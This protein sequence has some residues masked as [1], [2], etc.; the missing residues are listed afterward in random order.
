MSTQINVT[1]G[2]QRLLQNVQTRS[3]ANRQAL[4]D[5]QQNTKTIAEVTSALEQTE[6]RF[7][8]VSEFKLKR[9]PA[10]QRRKNKQEETQDRYQL[11][12]LLDYAPFAVENTATTFTSTWTYQNVIQAD[13]LIT[14]TIP[15]AVE[16]NFYID[17]TYRVKPTFIFDDNNYDLSVYE[18]PQVL[19]RTSRFDSTF[20]WLLETYVGYAYYVGGGT[21]G[22]PLQY[23]EKSLVSVNPTPFSRTSFTSNIAIVSPVLSSSNTALFASFCVRQWEYTFVPFFDGSSPVNNTG[24]RYARTRWLGLRLTSRR[25]L[26]YCVR[27]DRKTRTVQSKINTISVFEEP[28]GTS[29]NVGSTGLDGFTFTPSR[30]FNRAI[31]TV[32]EPLDNAERILYLQSMYSDDPRRRIYDTLG[33]TN[34]ALSTILRFISYD[35]ATGD[36]YFYTS[37]TNESPA[38]QYVY[39]AILPPDLDY[40]SA[41]NTLRAARF[42]V[43]TAFTVPKIFTVDKIEYTQ[44][45][46]FVANVDDPLTGIA[47][48][49]R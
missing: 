24:Y 26:S 20:S 25:L 44:I 15:V 30:Y 47:G 42:T 41:Y 43:L 2:D 36:A 35:V 16:E 17:E 33:N 21:T 11:Y 38:L 32:V 23:V 6:E 45:D 9:F 22:L 4:D 31:R 39:K 18:Q 8:S 37:N 5:R 1:V 40:L 10:A 12:K 49:K 27:F 13:P 19:R 48:F 34:E 3:A 14:V 28:F 29:P 7:N 46:T